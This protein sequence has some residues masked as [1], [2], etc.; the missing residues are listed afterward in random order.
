MEVLI[1]YISSR[2]YFYQ[3]LLEKKE[4]LKES[5]VTDNLNLIMH[6]L[7]RHNVAHF[8]DPP[9]NPAYKKMGDALDQVM[10]K[11]LLDRMRHVRR[12]IKEDIERYEIKIAPE[13]EKSYAQ[14]QEEPQT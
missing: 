5:E 4:R 2:W 11:D 3:G 12:S 1:S 9:G 8:E 14:T 10:I 13:T 7:L 6:C